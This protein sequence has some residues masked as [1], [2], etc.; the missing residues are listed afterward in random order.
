MQLMGIT[1]K[2]GTYVFFFTLILRLS[3]WS[4]S[5]LYKAIGGTKIYS[6]ILAITAG[7]LWNNRLPS[8]LVLEM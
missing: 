2:P 1:P 5:L 4:S 8:E 7:K 3:T 6:V